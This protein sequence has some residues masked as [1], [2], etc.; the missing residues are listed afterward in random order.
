MLGQAIKPAAGGI[1][2]VS[3]LS[4]DDLRKWAELWG[5]VNSDHYA[6]FYE[7]SVAEFLV[8]RWRLLDTV[9]KFLTAVAASGSTVAA[10]AV[11]SS[12][13]SGK[14]TWAITSGLTAILAL[15]HMSL[16]ISDR[17][18]EDTLIFSTFQ[19]LRLD[20]EIMKKKMRLGQHKTLAEYLNDYMNITS[21]FG[22]AYALKR[23]DFFLTR[24]REE[25][26]QA[27]INKRLGM[28]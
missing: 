17:I 8:S 5:F 6:C 18:K 2:E 22:K 26:I 3:E 11:W 28:E 23:P 24:T 1:E 7:E 16:G 25:K 19:Q 15:L 27:D 10:W 12:S 21:K 4:A 13:D 14:K 9:T 20:L